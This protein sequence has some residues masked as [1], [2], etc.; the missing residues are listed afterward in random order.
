VTPKPFAWKDRDTAARDMLQLVY[1]APSFIAERALRLLEGLRSPAVVTDLQSILWDKD[2]PPTWHMHA[3]RSIIATPGDFYMPSLS[4]YFGTSVY[5]Y[6]LLELADKHPSNQAWF[7]ECI[8]QLPLREQL[9]RL[10]SLNELAWFHSNVSHVQHKLCDRLMGLL[11]KHPH[12][13]TLRSADILHLADARSSTQAWLDS[14]WKTLLYL[15]MAHEYDNLV[16]TLE[17]WP[18]LRA[19]LFAACPSIIPEYEVRQEKIKSR[20]IRQRQEK[21]DITLSPYWQ[22]LA[23]LQAKALDGDSKAAD[24][25]VGLTHAGDV[26]EKAAAIY[27][28]GKL[29][30]HPRFFV[31]L[32]RLMLHTNESWVWHDEHEPDF[33]VTHYPVFYE[34]GEVL[35]KHPSPDVWQTLIDAYFRVP[36][37]TKT[38]VSWITYQT[39]KLSGLD[40][41]YKAENWPVEERSWFQVLARRD[42]QS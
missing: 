18:E 39:D 15:C 17:G 20:L 11:D 41:V 4:Q 22:D 27:F 38:M 8:D 35:S 26:L 24:K 32:K 36:A 1:H 33:L 6:E 14:H 13:M 42:L 9:K 12:L 23:Q 29:S 5:D 34:V 19:A 40:V 37:Y 25:L 2:W 16:N 21:I 3:L 10:C 7:F 28:W 31:R 30:Q